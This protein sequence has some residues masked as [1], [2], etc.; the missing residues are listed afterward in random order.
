VFLLLFVSISALRNPFHA[1]L[2]QRL[3]SWGLNLPPAL[4]ANF[5]ELRPNHYH[6]GLDCRPIISKPA[7]CGSE[8]YRK[9][10][11][12]PVGFGRSLYH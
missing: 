7:V 12:Q 6:S 1:Q 3:F 4:A 2:S 10:E 11:D 9:G 5:G 8:V